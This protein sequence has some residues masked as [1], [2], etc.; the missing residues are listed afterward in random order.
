ML[1]Y[2][3]LIVP[4]FLTALA[5]SENIPNTKFLFDT[6][7]KKTV[8]DFLCLDDGFKYREYTHDDDNITLSGSRQPSQEL[9]EKIAQ[10]AKEQ[11]KKLY[12]LDLRQEMHF[13]VPFSFSTARHTIPVC[14]HTENFSYNWFKPD[15]SVLAQEAE[16]VEAV[17]KE[18]TLPVY[19]IPKKIDVPSKKYTVDATGAIT[20]KELVERLGGIYIRFAITDHQRP[21]NEVVEQFVE[22]FR[23]LPCDAWVHIHCRGGS[24]RTTTLMLLFDMMQTNAEKDLDDYYV[25]QKTIG[26]ANIKKIKQEKGPYRTA[27]GHLRKEFIDHFYTYVRSGAFANGEGWVTWLK[28][29]PIPLKDTLD[30]AIKGEATLDQHQDVHS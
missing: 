23:S 9:L 13:L 12:V 7:K 21:T 11:G 29:N 18:K 27:C 17:K 16:I 15:F 28:K 14:L 22:F 5:A 24:G 19:F 10:K 8:E 4:F 25:H 6:G 2:L 30:K 26:G 20:E 3:Y 1:R